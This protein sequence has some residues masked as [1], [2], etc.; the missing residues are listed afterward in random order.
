MAGAISAWVLPREPG[1][2][3]GVGL[4]LIPV[5]VCGAMHAFGRWRRGHGHETTNLATFHGGAAFALATGAM[6]YV[7]LKS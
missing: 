2:F 7:L 4:V 1:R 5:V 3:A 6:R